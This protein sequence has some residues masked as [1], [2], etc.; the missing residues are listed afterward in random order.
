MLQNERWK[1]YHKMDMKT[2]EKTQDL[3][4]AEVRCSPYM[5]IRVVCSVNRFCFCLDLYHLH[6]DTQGF[7]MFWCFKCFCSHNWVFTHEK[8]AAFTLPFLPFVRFHLL[9][10]LSIIFQSLFFPLFNYNDYL[11]FDPKCSTVEIY[12]QGMKVYF[13]VFNGKVWIN[14]E[15]MHFNEVE[16]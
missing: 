3:E 14:W 2:I 5:I 8:R 4:P 10:S 16:Q 1:L 12:L 9:K 6:K 11:V 13:Y 15:N 7:L